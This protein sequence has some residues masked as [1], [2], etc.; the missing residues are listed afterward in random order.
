[1]GEVEIDATAKYYGPINV[2]E[3]HRI[4]KTLKN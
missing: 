4:L 1:M 3:M 2:Q